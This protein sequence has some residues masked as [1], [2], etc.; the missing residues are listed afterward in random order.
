MKIDITMEGLPE[1]KKLLENVKVAPKSNRLWAGIAQ[2]MRAESMKC[3]RK[4]RAPDG[5]PWKKLSDATL[6]ARAYRTTRGYRQRLKHMKGNQSVKFRRAMA[7]GTILQDRGVLKASVATKYTDTSAE[8]G[9]V[10]KYASVHQL[11]CKEKNIPPRP[12]LGVPER[13]MRVIVAMI[14]QAI[15]RAGK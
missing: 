10:L 6:R 12:F 7:S 13:G 4:Q 15:E 2:K 11:G 14:N 5:T 1:V 9:S 3:F 8:V